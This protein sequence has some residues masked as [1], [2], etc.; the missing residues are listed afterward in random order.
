M[1]KIETE[2]KGR[3]VSVE[4]MSAYRSLLEKAGRELSKIELEL[5]MSMLRYRTKYPNRTPWVRLEIIFNSSIEPTVK[6]E[7]LFEKTGRCAEIRHGNLFIIDP[8]I[9]L[10]NLEELARDKDIEYITGEII[11]P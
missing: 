9:T 2:L 4:L 8:F 7:E 11:P 3:P 10:E 6:K 1:S 5:V